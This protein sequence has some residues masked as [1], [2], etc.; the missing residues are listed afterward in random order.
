[1]LM[2]KA[3]IDRLLPS[4]KTAGFKM[5]GFFIWGGS[6]IKVDNRYHLFT[7]RW[8][9]DTK[10]PNG[11]RNHSEIVRSTS[12]TAMGPY[13]FQEV[14]VRGRGGKWWDGMMCHNPKIVQF[15]DNFILYYIGS[16]LKDKHRR[17]K[18]GYAY[19]KKITG[20]WTRIDKPFPFG[21]D[22]NNPAPFIHSDGSV[23]VAFRD[24]HLKM[25][26]SRASHWDGKYKIIA[27]DILKGI[28]VEDPDIHRVDGTYNMIV[29]D[30]RSQLTGKSRFG[31]HLLSK[32]GLN[33]E[34]NDP[35]IVY[36][37]TIQWDD[38]TSSTMERRERP[39]LFNDGAIVKG[40]G[41]PT[42]LL[43]AVLKDDN[44]WCQI[45]EISKN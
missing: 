41:K 42:H 45:Q 32:D 26:I 9:K 35:L 13:E 38:G 7:S 19:S 33:W 2:V 29:E 25:H 17:R 27:K 15:K 40:R 6:L 39:E 23:L 44:T 18:V 31:A 8:P 11:Y 24:H 36:S 43:T 14:V 28:K 4:P 22:H 10:F 16:A 37:H 21:K 12:K 1:M 5:R 30:N 20:P 3:L 34:K